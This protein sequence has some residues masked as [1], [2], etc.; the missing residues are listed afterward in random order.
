MKTDLIPFQHPILILFWVGLVVCGAWS[1]WI[2]IR[3][4]REIADARKTPP[5]YTIVQQIYR[6]LFYV[7]ALMKEHSELF[8][9]SPRR[10]HFARVVGC[11]AVLLALLAIALIILAALG[12]DF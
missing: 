6:R 5:R 7:Q 9:D 1:G 2:V 3:M 12:M 8:P 11:A 10:K 4:D